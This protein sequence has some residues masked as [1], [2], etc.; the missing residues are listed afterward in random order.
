[1]NDK[2]IVIIGAGITGLSLACR[3]APVFGSNIVIIEKEPFSG[4]LAATL[5]RDG[6]SFDLGSHRLHQKSDPVVMKYIKELICDD[7]LKMKR[8]G[9]L[10]FRDRYLNY[11]PFIF[12]FIRAFSVRELAAF[13]ASYIHHILRPKNGPDNYESVMI[14][15]VGKKMYDTFYRDF[16]FKIWGEDPRFI[17]TEGIRR[18]KTVVDWSSITRAIFCKNR[19]FFYPKH[20][21]GQ[22]AQEMEAEVLSYNC[23]IMKE[24]QVVDVRLDAGRIKSVKVKHASGLESEIDC[25][26]LASTIQI[27]DLY[28]LIF[29]EGPDIK[30][31]WRDMRL[32]YI[33]TDKPL[34]GES[35]TYYF[36][37]KEIVFGRVSDI[38]KYSP[39]INHRVKGTLLTLEIPTSP[40][41]ALWSLPEEAL[42]KRC[43]ED[44]IKTAV[45]DKD[46]EVL[47]YFSL[48]IPKVY[49]VYLLDW[50]KF[51]FAI[52]TRLSAIENLFS[53]GRNGLFAHINIDHCMIQGT[54]LGDYLITSAGN[55]KS[56]WEEKVKIFLKFCA[57]D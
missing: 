14:R 29:K 9:K 46:T 42:L 20:G 19:S 11:P 43:L 30:L 34:K 13:A 39:Y 38:R 24:S 2:K 36:H 27:D 17:S 48:R 22:I 1:M 47:N 21:I 23:R 8:R 51:F 3:L 44:L 18:R 56:G 57:R 26:I 54:A 31:K 37:S 32:F 25:G 49:P 33:L 41:D 50:G 5:F 52:Y 35:E 10:Y 28:H 6:L 16:A 15:R 55:G 40:G 4:G 7:R 45:L 12:N 53:L